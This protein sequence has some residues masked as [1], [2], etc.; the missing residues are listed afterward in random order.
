FYTA[1][2]HRVGTY[3]IEVNSGR[4]RVGAKRYRELMA[5]YAPAEGAGGPAGK[6]KPGQAEAGRGGAEVPV[7]LTVY[8]QAKAGK[9]SLINALLGERRA[10]TDVVPVTSE[11]TR[12]ALRRGGEE[13]LEV[14]DTVGYGQEGPREDQ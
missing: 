14:L 2:I 5:A 10:A 4:L 3:L 1:F 9:S 8:G 7:C 12:Y 6:E 11:V 13:S